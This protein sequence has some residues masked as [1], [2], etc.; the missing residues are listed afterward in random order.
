VHEAVVANI[1]GALEVIVASVSTIST[2][3]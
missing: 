3:E 2:M 1:L